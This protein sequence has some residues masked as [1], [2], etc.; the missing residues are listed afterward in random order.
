MGL[1]FPKNVVLNWFKYDLSF[2]LNLLS[3]YVQSLEEQI[4]ATAQKYKSDVES[5]VVE[6]YP[7][8]GYA[9]IVEIYK[10]LDSETWDL[11]G[12][13][14]EHFPSMQR[15]SALVIIMGFLESELDKL[16]RLY[17]SEK[18]FKVDVSDFGGKGIDR[19][20]DYLEKVAG[21]DVHRQSV[22]WNHIKKIQKTRNLI[23]HQ[24]GRLIDSQGNP[25]RAVIDYINQMDTLYGDREVGIKTGFLT[26]VL[27]IFDIY[28]TKLG[29]SIETS[30]N[31]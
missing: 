12:I 29:N 26:H 21:L 24:D 6:E 2:S 5:H 20:M 8:E 31:A 28:L 11:D 13:F 17:K 1:D 9:R 30:E 7:E 25:I 15:R 10:G 14:I 16:C 18:E 3:S 19:S 27:E 4:V 23:V 22:E